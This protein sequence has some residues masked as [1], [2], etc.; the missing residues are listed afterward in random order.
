MAGRLEQIEDMLKARIGSAFL[1]AHP[2]IPYTVH[3]FL[4]GHFT[5]DELLSVI[6]EKIDS[7]LFNLIYDGTAKS[8][9]LCLDDGTSI[10]I[11][12]DSITSLAD[13]LV[14]LLYLTEAPSSEWQAAL[15]DL[16]RSGSFCAMQELLSRYPLTK[17]ERDIFIRILSENHVLNKEEYV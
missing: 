8:M 3:R 16:S 5:K 6:W 10:R 1:V 7:Y 17:E 9:R 11:T 12:E 15:Y 2:E 4:L 14:S 13:H